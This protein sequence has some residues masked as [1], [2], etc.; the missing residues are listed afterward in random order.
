MQRAHLYR[1]AVL[2]RFDLV[3]RPRAT[4]DTAGRRPKSITPPRR[5]KSTATP[6]STGNVALH[7]VPTDA[8]FFSPQS[9][10]GLTLHVR[11][12]NQG[13]LA[14]RA[15]GMDQRERHPILLAGDT[16]ISVTSCGRLER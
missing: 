15:S 6:E 14:S 1:D 11:N 16:S 9:R 13:A 12:A 3:I 10:N 2:R 8:A 5:C 7:T 4:N